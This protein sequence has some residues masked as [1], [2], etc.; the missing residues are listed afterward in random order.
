MQQGMFVHDGSMPWN[1]QGF[2][3]C[4]L[5]KGCSVDAAQ[6]VP[7]TKIWCCALLCC[8][9]LV[10]AAAAAGAAACLCFRCDGSCVACWSV[11]DTL[12]QEAIAEQQQQQQQF[13]LLGSFA[14]QLQLSSLSSLEQ[15]STT[16]AASVMYQ[17]LVMCS[18]RIPSADQRLGVS[19]NLLWVE[20]SSGLA[21]G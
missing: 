17:P 20:T 18:S 14:Q 10:S 5:S 19:A 1:C 12:D 6:C 11:K 21:A 16:S 15:P 4:V 3:G 7:C 2:T 8:A 13:G 9:L